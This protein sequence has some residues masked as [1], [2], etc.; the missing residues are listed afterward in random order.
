MTEMIKFHG[1]NPYNRLQENLI[2][3]GIK[4]VKIGDNGRR[5][6]VTTR[7]VKA[8]DKNLKLNL[9]LWVITQK[10]GSKKIARY[11]GTTNIP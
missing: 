4:G 3:G 6:R 5:R 11:K 9:A 2:S 8:L 7:P 1:Y 10:M